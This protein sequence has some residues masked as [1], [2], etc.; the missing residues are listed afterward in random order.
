MPFWLCVTPS[1][2]P[3]TKMN[4]IV[5]HLKLLGAVRKGKSKASSTCLKSTSGITFFS[6]VKVK[7]NIRYLKAETFTSGMIGWT[8]TSGQEGQSTLR[9]RLSGW[10]DRQVEQKKPG[11]ACYP[12]S[13]G[14]QGAEYSLSR[15]GRGGRYLL[16]GWLGILFNCMIWM[17]VFHPPPKESHCVISDIS[18]RST[19]IAFYTFWGP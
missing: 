8:G 14:Q 10:K 7:Q 16:Y 13:Q 12:A 4:P 11:R 3:E 5:S 19:I 15:P 18:A 2:A 9:G 17:T 1:G 6:P